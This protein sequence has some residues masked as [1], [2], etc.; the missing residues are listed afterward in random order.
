MEASP[1]VRVYG[2]LRTAHLERFR[3][4]VPARVLYWTTRYDYDPVHNTIIISKTLDSANV[5][6]FFIEYVLYHEM[7]HIKHKARIIRGRC[8]YHTAE[9]Y[10]DE[11]QFQQYKEAMTW[12]DE[13]TARYSR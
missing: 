8:Y 2:R 13:F 10:L 12:L 4:M 9:F 7:L 6:E 3:K 11:K 1:N 5:P